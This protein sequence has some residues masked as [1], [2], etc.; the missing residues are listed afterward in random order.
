MTSSFD[1]YH[2]WLGIAPDEQPVNH[3]R[4]LGVRLYE[5]DPNVLQN[6]ADQRM[7]HLRTFQ[8]GP[9]CQ[10]SQRLLNEIA[11]A[12]R[13][14]LTPDLR[15]RYDDEF[16]REQCHNQTQALVSYGAVP[17]GAP[18]ATLA[19]PITTMPPP[20]PPPREPA[21]VIASQP[22]RIQVSGTPV[23]KRR[24]ESTD[25]V[26]AVAKVIAGGVAGLAIGVLFLWGI[27][28][29]DPFGLFGSKA[30]A[31]REL[32]SP[33]TISP[34]LAKPVTVVKVS[35]QQ[36]GQ[37]KPTP[38]L[39]TNPVAETRAG[40]PLPLAAEPTKPSTE[41]QPQPLTLAD[42]AVY[43]S[44]LPPIEVVA[45][46]VPTVPVRVHGQQSA[47]GIFLH[48][49][50]NSTAKISFGLARKYRSLTG[51]AADHAQPREQPLAQVAKCQPLQQHKLHPR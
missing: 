49:A 8:V 35:P 17:D 51:A 29:V 9:R 20:V 13:C 16:R 38:A 37:P 33:V 39:L 30:T 41:P 18:I 4:L 31:K 22:S 14:L 12:L 2:Q 24:S 47:H 40:V 45:L 50:A 32:V 25:A 6:A 27:A 46:G 3:Y 1:P 21:P 15:A 19:R 42:S 7:A 44:E 23:N 28:G 43:L 36:A 10:L 11:S 26:V 48:P 5:G 34:P